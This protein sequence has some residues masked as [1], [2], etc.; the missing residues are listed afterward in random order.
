MAHK[1][2]DDLIKFLSNHEE[3]SNDQLSDINAILQRSK[4]AKTVS[5]K[6][7]VS[8]FDAKSYDSKVFIERNANRLSLTMHSVS[9]NKETALLAKGSDAVCIFVND[10]CSREVIERLSIYGIKLIALRCAGFNNVDLE[11]C[12]EFGIS[13]VRVPA[14]SPH[15]VA[16]HTIALMLMLNRNLHKAYM[17]NRSGQFTLDGLVGFDMFGKTVGIIGT[18]KIGE[19]VIDILLGFGCKVLAY[20]KYPKP[21]LF[22]NKP[23]SYV[24]LDVLLRESDI[25]SL[26]APLLEDTHHCI[27]AQSIEM[28]KDGCIIINTSRGGLVDS[29]AL[30]QGLKTKKIKAAGLDVYEEEADI[31]FQDKSNDVIDDDVFS[32]LLSFNNVVITSHQAFLTAEALNNIADTTIENMLSFASGQRGSEL[33]NSVLD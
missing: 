15:A 1:N 23:V 8:M 17:K 16:E 24:E 31:F 33:D 13:V 21:H 30:I 29:Q 27:N 19:C 11:A 18:G 6:F 25:I 22:E 2:K 7:S 9:L 3:L 28:M 5:T 4:S 14:Y 32:R 26:H 10:V 20:D 12:R